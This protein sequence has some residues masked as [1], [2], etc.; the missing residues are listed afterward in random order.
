M[1]RKGEP[2]EEPGTL[3]GIALPARDLGMPRDDIAEGQGRHE[4]E[5]EDLPVRQG[6][7]FR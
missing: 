6:D 1:D 3:S 4:Q 2:E 5:E 7:E